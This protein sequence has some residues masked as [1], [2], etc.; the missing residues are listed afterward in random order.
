MSQEPETV[1]SPVPPATLPR[2]SSP[3]P[4]ETPLFL[5]S[6]DRPVYAVW[7]PPRPGRPGAPALVFCHSLGVEQ[8]TDYRNEVLAARAAAAAGFPALRFHA[9]GHGDSAGDFAA[10]TLETLVADARMAADFAR[11]RAGGSRLVW[12]GVRFG[13]LVAAGALARRDDAAGLVL[14]EP[15]HRPGDYFRAQLRGMLFSEVAAGHA[16]GVTV[17]ELLARVEREGQVDVH[18]YYLHRAL[19]ES[20]READLGQ[21][22]AGWS[23]PTRLVQVAAR[24]RLAAAH[25]ALA[26]ALESHGARVATACVAVEPGWH[27]FNNPAWESP[28]LVRGTVEWLDALA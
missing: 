19:V 13:A 26:A 28:E 9:R 11:E 16:P 25:A 5:A 23:G 1:P 20:A 21:Y 22:L 6:A 27:F 24:P 15:V 2:P 4:A 8:L 18:G 7:H 3:L 17:D 10:V 14:W 12:L